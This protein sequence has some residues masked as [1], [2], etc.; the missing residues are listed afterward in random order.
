MIHRHRSD[1]RHNLMLIA[2]ASHPREEELH[3]DVHLHSEGD[4]SEG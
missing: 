2:E 3:S 4:C 1:E